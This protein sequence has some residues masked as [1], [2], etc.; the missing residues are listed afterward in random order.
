MG[1]T[2]ENT[3][4]LSNSGPASH[5]GRNGGGH[6]ALLAVLILASSASVTES[7]WPFSRSSEAPGQS[8]KLRSPS[9]EL[10]PP[11][12]VREGRELMEQA[13]ETV[14]RY[15]RDARAVT[16]AMG[17]VD[18]FN[19]ALNLLDGETCKHMS[20]ETRAR[21]ALEL[22][23]CQL[24]L[25]GE[26]MGDCPRSVPL[27]ECFA[28]MPERVYITF[29]EFFAHVD[30]MCLHLQSEDFERHVEGLV[31][32]LWGSSAVAADALANISASLG[33]EAAQLEAVQLG[34][35][36]LQR[37]GDRI[38]KGVGTSL[39]HLAQVKGA[40]ENL[41]RGVG[42]ALASQDKLVEKQA[43]LLA[44]LPL[45]RRLRRIELPLPI[46]AGRQRRSRQRG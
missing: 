39:T 10:V 11:N 34:L 38:A 33:R 7:F 32:T 5:H 19:Q 46:P 16:T 17:P 4:A 14:A 45:W 44:G 13:K 26:P 27:P 15:G 2:N 18:C 42:R 1:S 29:N 30:G 23:R 40:T 22:T 8:I 6:C 25:L 41:E 21:F 37:Q 43:A 20:H 36:G 31:A 3:R 28:R 24:S 35:D 9:F 12:V